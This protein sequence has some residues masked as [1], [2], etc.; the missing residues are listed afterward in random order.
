MS[1]RLTEA[2]ELLRD[3]GIS[4]FL[5]RV[6]ES[7]HCRYVR[8]HLP[9]RIARYNGFRVRAPRLFD[10]LLRSERFHRPSYESDIIDSLESRVQPGDEVV[11]V[12]GGLGVS[13]VAAAKR[14]GHRGRVT[15]FE[16]ASELVTRIRE[17]AELNGV[18]DRI[19]VHH[20]IVGPEIHL[21]GAADEA[22]RVL[23]EELP[24]C[25]VLE[26]DCEGAELAI[27]DALDIAPRV[28][29]VETHGLFDAPTTTV[30]DSIV[31]NGY[32]V[33]AEVIADEDLIDICISDDIFVITAVDI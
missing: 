4:G 11:I 7:L 23:P 10:S 16:G 29:I 17:T 1:N 33:I 3:E 13:A 6:G 30:R 19:E 8:P 12:G 5:R 18:S 28:L 27:L 20:A 9:R 15:V 24:V 14:A 21:R 31:E 2:G 26:L 22:A 32:V 25:D